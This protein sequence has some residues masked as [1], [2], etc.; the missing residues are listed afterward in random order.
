M[1]LEDQKEDKQPLLN[2]DET[3]LQQETL[4]V[5]SAVSSFPPISKQQQAQQQS[6]TTT[7]S[8]EQATAEIG[9]ENTE[10]K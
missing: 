9:T 3:E 5:T 6:A 7:V 8:T 4:G 10:C 1:T 2:N